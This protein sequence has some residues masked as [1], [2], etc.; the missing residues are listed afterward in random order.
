LVV[1]RPFQ[2]SAFVSK[3]IFMEKKGTKTVRNEPGQAWEMIWNELK[4]A[5]ILRGQSG[6]VEADIRWGDNALMAIQ[7]LQEAKLPPAEVANVGMLLQAAIHAAEIYWRPDNVSSER[8]DRP[9]PT[10]K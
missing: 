5:G 6:P 3:E 7:R 1:S 8:R 4:R 2:E 9:R 10:K